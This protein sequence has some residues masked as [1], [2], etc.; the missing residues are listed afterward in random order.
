MEEK[1]ENSAKNVQRS[2]LTTAGFVLGILGFVTCG[3]TSLIG[4]ILSII[5]LSDSKK[6]GQADGLAIAG[7]V[8]SAIPMA[9]GVILLI[10]GVG[11][12]SNEINTIKDESTTKTEEKNNATE[13]TYMTVNIDDLETE[14]DNNPAAAKDK[15][16]GKNVEVTGNLGVIDSDLKYI[17]LKSKNDS[18][19]SIH[20][21]IKNSATKDVVKTLEKDQTITIKGKITDVG[22]LLGYRLDI[23]EIIPQ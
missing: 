5:G 21:S 17:S 11:A 6:K 23:D 16:K 19:K 10:A 8:L 3:L 22:E 7:I 2:G 12:S 9:I 20:C 14:R 1:K 13:K 15:Y 4:L 18:W